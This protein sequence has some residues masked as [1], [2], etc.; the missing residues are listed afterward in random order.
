MIKY[1]MNIK[2]IFTQVN[3]LYKLNYSSLFFIF[4]F[5]SIKNAFR[6]KWIINNLVICIT[7]QSVK[8]KELGCFDIWLSLILTYWKCQGLTCSNHLP[9]KLDSADSTFS[10]I[11][12]WVHSCLIGIYT[13]KIKA[14]ITK[15]LVFYHQLR[16]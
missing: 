4:S 14:L 7:K 13:F 16:L 11:P 2:C 10:T 1:L 9:S 8:I 6:D 12:L 15:K 3:R 5:L